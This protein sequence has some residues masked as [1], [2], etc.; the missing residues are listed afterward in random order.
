MCTRV[1][2]C[3]PHM[4]EIVSNL[5]FFPLPFV[6][7]RPSAAV[8]KTP[9]WSQLIEERVHL[10]LNIPAGYES[11]P[12]A[13]GKCG[14]KQTWWQERQRVHISANSKQRGHWKQG[15]SWETPSQSSVAFPPLRPHLLALPQTV[16]NC[17]P[18]I[19]SPEAYGGHPIRTTTPCLIPF[20]FQ[21]PPSPPQSPLVSCHICALFLDST[22]ERKYMIFVHLTYFVFHSNSW[23]QAFF[24]K[25]YNFTLHY[26]W[27]KLCWTYTSSS[28]HLSTDGHFA[29][30]YTLATVHSVAINTDGQ[31]TLWL[32][33]TDVQVSLW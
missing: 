13:V 5:F 19:Q 24:W 30:F 11:M 8:I 20:S 9:W 26:S 3:A 32:I 28:T 27:M 17:R 10:G 14:S 12:N 15:E 6:S 22:Y 21:H 2:V 25:W 16:T 31:V 23:F 29:Y 1:Y 7:V 33:H 4:R 18:S